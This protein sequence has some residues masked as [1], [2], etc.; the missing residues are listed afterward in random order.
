M[1]SLSKR[2]GHFAPSD[3][4]IDFGKPELVE[5]SA[6][7]SV[8]D[9]PRRALSRRDPLPTRGG[10]LGDARSAAS[11]PTAAETQSRDCARRSVG[12]RP[13]AVRRS[14]PAALRRLSTPRLSRDGLRAMAIGRSRSRDDWVLRLSS[15]PTSLL[16]RQFATIARHGFTNVETFAPLYDDVAGDETPARRPWSQREERAFQ[17]RDRSGEWDSGT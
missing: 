11:R 10:L 4:K 16:A 13:K 17:P 6:R 15:R 12:R 1:M 9:R 3:I 5:R 7:S 2:S 14:R 8:A